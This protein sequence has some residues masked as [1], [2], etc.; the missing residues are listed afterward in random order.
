MRIDKWLNSVN[1]V[2]KRT[3]SLDMIKSGVI[4]LNGEKVK[5]SKNVKVGDKIIIEYLKSKKEYEVLQIPFLK[6]IPK[7]D[8][9]KYF[10]LLD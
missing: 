9:Y 2:K 5:A 7:V 3:I 6:V 8:N 1:I 10:K 4:S